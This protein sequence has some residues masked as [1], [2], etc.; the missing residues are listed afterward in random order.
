M[1]T[2]GLVVYYAIK[3]AV[4]MFTQGL[5]REVGPRGITVNNIQSRPIDTDLI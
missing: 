5:A 3:G 4:K 2:P 1:M